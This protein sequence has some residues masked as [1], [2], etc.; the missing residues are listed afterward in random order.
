MSGL[1]SESS[2]PE[3]TIPVVPEGQGRIA[4]CISLIG[5][6]DP[7][8]PKDPTASGFGAEATQTATC[9]LGQSL[10]AP[11]VDT[12]TLVRGRQTD[13]QTHPCTVYKSRK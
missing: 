7:E 5:G 3:L 8:S 9:Q 13:T 6:L 11:S 10:L 2:C 4:A 1:L 12:E